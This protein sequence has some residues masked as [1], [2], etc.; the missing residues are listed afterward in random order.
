MK[1]DGFEVLGNWTGT[2]SSFRLPA[3]GFFLCLSKGWFSKAIINHV[4]TAQAIVIGEQ[5][6]ASGTK[7]S[8]YREI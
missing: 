5:L 4:V 1:T 6:S 2:D 8:S 3:R 7:C